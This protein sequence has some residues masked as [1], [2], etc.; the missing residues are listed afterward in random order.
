METRIFLRLLGLLS[1]VFITVVSA[2]G[3]YTSSDPRGS[4]L[5]SQSIL[6]Q[7]TI[8]LD[9]YKE[10]V[11]DRYGCV[12]TDH[13]D[14]YNCVIYRK[15]GHYYYYFP[16]GASI[17]SIPVVAV[18]NIAGFDVLSYFNY[19]VSL[20][21]IISAICAILTCCCLF[22]LAH[23]YLGKNKSLML[24]AIAWF[25]TSFAST[26]A[27]ALWSHNFATL[28]ALVAIYLSVRSAKLQNYKLWPVL[29][30]SLFFSYLCRPT[31]ILLVPFLILYIFLSNK[32]IAIFVSLLF[33]G[34]MLVFMG[35]SFYEFKQILPDYYSLTRLSG[36]DS[37]LEAL[38]GNLL[39]PSRGLVVF[40]PIFLLPVLFSKSFYLSIKN[41]KALLLLLVWPVVHW[42]VISRFPHWWAGWSYG[43]RLMTDVLPGF[44]L[45]L[46]LT[47]KR[48]E[49]S[50][51]LPLGALLVLGALS[52]YI[53]TFQ[54][55]FNEYTPRWNAQPDIDQ[56]PEYLF[57]WRYPQF[58]HNRERHE[59]RLREF[60]QRQS[61]SAPAR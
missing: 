13:P 21:V 49:L 2:K 14:W 3:I 55:L 37:F 48:M 7:G 29:A 53:N 60:N 19:E 61:E 42:I 47:V 32:K 9:A 25:G 39:S 52:I 6:K 57:D 22:S 59:A 51:P 20:Q 12:I 16:L 58:L 15:N 46:V 36:N 23:L 33:S 24:S 56:H 40:S 43:P 45:L 26:T 28:F 35:F 27:T 50:R 54:G 11:F 41:Q 38:Y 4:V 8:K 10:S 31:L 44:Y 18:F 5:V 17:V 34:C 1:I 30:I